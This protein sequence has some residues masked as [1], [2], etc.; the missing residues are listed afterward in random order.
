M[1]ADNTST[2]EASPHQGKR[3]CMLSSEAL[4]TETK[5]AAERFP[6]SCEQAA[7]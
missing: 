7:V 2:E 3:G 4:P 6:C 1:G 5:L